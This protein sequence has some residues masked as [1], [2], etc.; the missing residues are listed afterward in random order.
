MNSA[1][2]RIFWGYFFIFFDLY[3]GIDLLMDPVGYLLIYSGCTKIAVAFPQSKKP[4]IVALVGMIASIPSVLVNLSDPVLD[5]SWSV[6]G[7]GL[8]IIKLIVA[9]YL[10]LLLMEI[11]KSFDMTA[12]IQR[13]STTF[14]YFIGF[15]LFTFALMSFLVN[16]SGDGWIVLN[17]IA[18]I[19]VLIMDIIFLFLLRAI[20]KAAPDS[21]QIDMT[22]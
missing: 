16:T 7:N 3:I 11:V 17:L 1:L 13:T 19:G 5:Y 8:F 4:R 18:I 6:Y 2:R 9:F 22:V 20:R 12:L 15:Y 10:F 21:V 14:K